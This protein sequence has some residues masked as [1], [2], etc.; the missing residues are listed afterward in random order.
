ML[1]FFYSLFI[2]LFSLNAFAQVF[3][4]SSGG[5]SGPSMSKGFYVSIAA[6]GGLG[7]AGSDDESV[8]SR[9]FSYYGAEATL[10]YR[11]GRL[12]I[13]GSADYNIWAQRTKPSKVDNTNMSGKQLNLAPIAG[14]AIGPFLLAAKAHISSTMTLDK[15]TESGDKVEYSAPNLPAYT[16]QINYRLGGGSFIGLEY[17]NVT[18]KKMKSGSESANLSG[19]E[20]ISYS[21]WG[22]VY[23]YMF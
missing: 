20:Q 14:V 3:P 4:Q 6:R 22:V 11:F 9:D 8:K 16:A 1:S 17:T 10:G 2:F 5:S 13:G 12:L 15:K 21:G 7:N 23:G 18:Y 19:K